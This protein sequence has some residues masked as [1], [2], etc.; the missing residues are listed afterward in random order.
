M[1]ARKAGA[2]VAAE[3][4]NR[5]PEPNSSLGGNDRLIAHQ[6]ETTKAVDPFDDIRK[7]FDPLDDIRSSVELGFAVIRAR[8]RSGGRGWGT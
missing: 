8:V 2:S 4:A 5:S 1:E 6:P 3:T 7:A